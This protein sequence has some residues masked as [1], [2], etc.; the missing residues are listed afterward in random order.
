V[1][2]SADSGEL[3]EEIPL[4]DEAKEVTAAG[5]NFAVFP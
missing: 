2:I 5:G 1:V 3:Q 4:E